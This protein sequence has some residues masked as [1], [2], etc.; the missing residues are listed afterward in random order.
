M[1]NGVLSGAMPPGPERRD[2]EALRGRATYSTIL[3]PKGRMVTDLRVFRLDVGGAGPAPVGRPGAPVALP[4]AGAGGEALL[5]D[6][7]ADG[8]PGALD[9]FSRTVPP[10]FAA[11]EDVSAATGHLTLLGPGA[12]ALVTREAL[13]LRVDDAELEALAE[14]QYVAV[15]SG[16]GRLLHVARCG[17]VATPALDVMA[18]RR[19]VEALWRRLLEAGARPAGHAVWETLRVEAG[20]PAFGVDM[21]EGRIPMEAGLGERAIDHRKGCY[22]GQEVIVRIRDRGHV[23]R[24]LRGLRL[25]EAPTPARG[26]PL[27]APEVRDEAPVGEVT[28]AVQSPRF[29]EAIAMGYVRREVE[30][31]AVVRVGSVEGGEAVVVALE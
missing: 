6:F 29:G 13:G 26:T 17:D 18:D 30:P 10:R 20:R 3:T 15:D 7:P 27:F 1:L 25:G 5:L 24:Y 8:L 31:G 12:P 28:S 11:V 23:N 16:D 4:G 14:G 9:H 2:G 21:D 19:T 22:T